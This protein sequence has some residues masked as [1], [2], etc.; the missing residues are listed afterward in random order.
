[1]AAVAVVAFNLR[2]AITAIS[3]V[4]AEIQ[5]STGLTAAEAGLL[6]T[7]PVLAF[8]ACA[9]LAPWLGR[10]L[11]METALVGSLVLLGA[12]VLVRSVPALAPLFVGTVAIGVA[13]AIGN[14][15]VP[16]L[17]K[18]DFP[19][20]PRLMT[21]IYSVA[22][23][24]GAAVAAGVAVPLDA[25]VGGWRLGLAFWAAPLVVC[26]GLWGLRLRDA[27]HDIGAVHVSGR[28]WRDARAWQVTA[29]MGL[30]SLGFYATVAWLPT[31]FEQQGMSPADAGWLLSL[32]GFAS[33]PAAFVAPVLA[34]TVPR[35]RVAVAVAVGL[36]AVALSGL[37][38]HSRAGAVVWMVLLGVAQGAA[39]S[40]A[41]TFIVA[42]APDTARAAELSGMA[43]TVGYLVAGLGPFA[44]GALRDASGRWTLP[45]LVLAAVLAPQLA[46]G[47]GAARPGTVGAPRA[48]PA[49][50]PGGAH[51]RRR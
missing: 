30:Q 38:W 11:G 21:G 14:V 12:G 31:I 50:D 25:A 33:L 45:L 2:P 19:H 49:T 42:R 47:L 15:L 23:S 44:L 34:S 48:A 24:G 41:L 51:T 9:P 37:L 3:P 13:V 35:Q 46:S 1:M 7:I 27:H 5:R 4:L 36:N 29:Y 6:T 17:V 32:A 8:G 43:Q 22:L 26:I 28:L 40:L 10:R 20:D 16:A 39:L 18:R